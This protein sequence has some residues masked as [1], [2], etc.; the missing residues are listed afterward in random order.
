MSRI[1]KILFFAVIVKPLVLVGL[2][3]NVLNRRDLPSLGPAVIAANHNSH[4]DTIVLMSL[5]PLRQLHRVRPVAAADYFLANRF[6]AWFSLNIIGIIPL[7]RTGGT[8]LDHLFDTCR[9]ALDHDEIL[10]LF[11]EGSRGEAEQLGRVRKGIYRL[12]EGREETPVTP[13]VMYG[14]GRALPRGEALFVPFNCDVVIGEPMCIEG[15]SSEFTRKL[16]EIYS[17]LLT[18]CLTRHEDEV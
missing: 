6:L 8:G 9:E 14:L 17:E 7:D 12:L 2:G 18:H 5:F 4:L 1:L 13:V 11:P 3:L 15:T 16:S 10:V